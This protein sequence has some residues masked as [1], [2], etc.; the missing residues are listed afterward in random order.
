MMP[1]IPHM[2]LA[3]LLLSCSG[4]SREDVQVLLDVPV[5]HVAQ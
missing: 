5:G 2:V 4:S 1:A 3:Y